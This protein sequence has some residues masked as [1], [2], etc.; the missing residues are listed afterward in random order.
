MNHCNCNNDDNNF[1]IIVGLLF[2]NC[3]IVNDSFEKVHAFPICWTIFVN[4][5][6]FVNPV[7]LL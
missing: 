2:E 6:V 3:F 4:I 1:I 7:Y 5:Q